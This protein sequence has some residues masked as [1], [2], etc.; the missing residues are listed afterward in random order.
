MN[1]LPA[2]VEVLEP[3]AGAFREQRFR[4]P[5]PTHAVLWEG[6][7]LAV[8]LAIV[9][10]LVPFTA[11]GVLVVLSYFNAEVK[12]TDFMDPIVMI[13]CFM[14]PLAAAILLNALVHRWSYYEISVTAD[15]LQVR[16]R[17]GPF[18]RTRH[19]RLA[20]LK[21]LRVQIG[22]LQHLTMR[23]VEPLDPRSR[24]R[25]VGTLFADFELS[26][27]QLI[28]S[29]YD[30]DWLLSIASELTRVIE[31]NHPGAARLMPVTLTHDDPRVILDRAEQPSSSNARVLQ[32][33][34]RLVI[35]MPPHGWWR[36]FPWQFQYFCYFCLAMLLVWTVLLVRGELLVASE[37]GG[38]LGP[39]PLLIGLL[40]TSPCYAIIGCL[41]ALWYS[42]SRSSARWEITPQQLCLWQRTIWGE[43]C[44]FW[45]RSELQAIR[46]VSKLHQQSDRD[47]IFYNCLEI[48]S[49]NQPPR[50][51][52]RER[53]KSELEWL[54]T[55]LR[56]G[57]GHE[58]PS[59]IKS[60]EKLPAI[61]T[62]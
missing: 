62:E 21:G 36:S 27:Q 17:I 20:G 35:E 25:N 60:C 56:K 23:G 15:R 61:H 49:A 18:F 58:S 12:P 8:G 31:T 44:A 43:Y 57:L 40:I 28:V 34:D 33:V 9:L 39:L 2:D 53:D 11:A 6:Y 32:T 10:F 19:L 45:N 30:P 16:T 14:L 1:T 59:A 38:N 50:E 7:W 29:G 51:F 5:A 41:L 55:V 24:F 13:G 4:L 47:D 22:T 52:F 37:D 48:T 46:V 26:P 54:A 42:T 3:V